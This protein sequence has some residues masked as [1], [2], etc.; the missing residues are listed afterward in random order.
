MA[1]GAYPGEGAGSGGDPGQVF[2]NRLVRAAAAHAG[3]LVTYVIAIYAGKTGPDGRTDGTVPM[4]AALILTVLGPFALLSTLTLNPDPRAD[5]RWLA[6]V[7]TLSGKAK[8]W[9]AFGLFV[10]WCGLIAAGIEAARRWD[11]RLEAVLAFALGHGAVAVLVGGCEFESEDEYRRRVGLSPRSPAPAP[12]APPSVAPE[13]P[14]AT[15]AYDRRL[16]ELATGLRVHYLRLRPRLGALLGEDEVRRDARWLLG[17][18]ARTSGTDL[19]RLLA[20]A[21]RCA[22]RIRERYEKL[23]LRAETEARYEALREEIGGE[24]PPQVFAEDVR[25]HLDLELPLDYLREAA[26]R[27]TAHMERLSAERARPG[28]DRPAGDAPADADEREA[29]VR[30]ARERRVAEQVAVLERRMEEEIAEVRSARLERAQTEEAVAFIRETYA[31]RV[32]E[33][34]RAEP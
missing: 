24:Y 18:H 2:F 17:S 20:C 19:A 26:G 16:R 28:G 7:G 27:L 13:D 29:G 12:P 9:I 4:V 14:E 30:A 25:D 32:S 10:G 23:A 5:E 15:A 33:V 21:E 3:V 1:T 22:G 34:R 8:G 11:S 31:A 6:T